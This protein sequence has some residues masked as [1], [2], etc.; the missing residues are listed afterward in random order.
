[1]NLRFLLFILIIFN[2]IF[3]NFSFASDDGTNDNDYNYYS[4]LVFRLIYNIPEVRKVNNELYEAYYDLKLA[5]S[6]Y[7]IN[8]DAYYNYGYNQPTVKINIGPNTINISNDF[9]YNYGLKLTKLL[10]SFNFVENIIISKQINYYSKYLKFRQS[11]NDNYLK[12]YELMAAAVKAK[13]FLDYTNNLIN[14]TNEFLKTSYN[15]YSVGIIPKLDYIKAQ[16]VYQDSITQNV[17]A[18]DNYKLAKQSL[19]AFLDTDETSFNI[20]NFI[21]NIYK[22]NYQDKIY[23]KDQYINIDLDF[24]NKLNKESKELL[25]A[26]ILYSSI[27]VLKYQAKSLDYQNAPKLLLTATY[28]KHRPT[29]FS[30]D[31]TFNINLSLSWKLFDSNNSY[32]SKQLVL[33]NISSLYEDYKRL[34]INLDLAKSNYKTKFINNYNT[35]ISSYKTL[36]YQRELF[37]INKLRYENGLYTYLEYLDAQNSL[38]QS[39]LNLNNIKS[40][41]LLNYVYLLYYND[42]DLSLNNFLN[43]FFKIVK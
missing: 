20:D 3:V 12:F 17:L 15:L 13:D 26:K 19:L 28:D 25:V 4:N 27:E 5:Y 29:G 8:L 18:Q 40:D 33:Q 34:I 30:R 10:Y 11:L 23:L 39:E 35:L 6:Q 2:I 38:L 14:Y 37:R 41:L 1:M 9:P 42:I 31:Y 7:G 21:S 43:Y 16:S 24:I 32:Y 22:A 36:N